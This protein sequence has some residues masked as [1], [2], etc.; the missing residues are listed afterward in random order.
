M[1]NLNVGSVNPCPPLKKRKL[2]QKKTV[3]DLQ[4]PY[5]NRMPNTDICFVI[6]RLEFAR[7]VTLI[8]LSYLLLLDN[9]LEKY[10]YESG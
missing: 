4:T 3:E 7:P 10:T 2:A 5:G 6:Q 8:L 1:F 9:P